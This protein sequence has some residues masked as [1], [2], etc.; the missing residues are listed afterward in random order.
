VGGVVDP[1]TGEV[2]WTMHVPLAEQRAFYHAHPPPSLAE[3]RATPAEAKGF[4]FD[5]H[6]EPVNAVFAVACPCG[7]DRFVALGYRDEDEPPEPPIT[8]ECARCKKEHVVFDPARH[9]YDGVHHGLPHEPDG[10]LEE[11]VWE[12]LDDDYP[13]LVRFE[14]PSDHLGDAEWAGREPELY[15]WISILGRS[16]DGNL[17]LLFDWECA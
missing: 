9:G 8:L 13:V 5:G 14:Y 17:V 3:L 4:T 1:K 12:D 16:D 10:E 15:S 6:G 2:V 7:S 11:L